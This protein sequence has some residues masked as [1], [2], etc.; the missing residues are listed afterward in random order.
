VQSPELKN[1]SVKQEHV[2]GQ[3]TNSIILTIHPIVHTCIH[4]QTCIYLAR[5]T[6]MATT[7]VL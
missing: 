6:I 4:I 2:E 1:T 7:V 5:V 3:F